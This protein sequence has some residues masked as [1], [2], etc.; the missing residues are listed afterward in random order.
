MNCRQAKKVALSFIA[1]ISHDTLLRIIQSTSIE[2]PQTTCVGVDDF[3]FRKKHHYGTLICDLKTHKPL[4]ILPKR[5]SETVENWLKNYPS[6][7]I[8]SRDGANAFREAIRKANPS[9]IQVSDRWHIIKNARESLEKWLEQRLPHQIEWATEPATSSH[10]Q[11]SE[12]PI[13]LSKWVLI[14]QIQ[15]DFQSGLHVSHLAKI[16]QLSRSTIYKYIRQC[17]PPRKTKRKSKPAQIQLQPFY[18]SIITYDAQRLTFQQILENIRAEGYTGSKSAV[19]R[20]LEPY[21]TNKKV[22][23]YLLINTLVPL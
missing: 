7:Q 23:R 9:I 6:I 22:L 4:A 18:E 3:A 2:L 8:V 17:T 15:K 12:T 20:F 1:P 19:R 10:D 5:T 21:R 11:P 13:D 14:Q 16:Y